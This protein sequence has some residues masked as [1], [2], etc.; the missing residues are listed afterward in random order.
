M[1]LMLRPPIS[2]ISMSWRLSSVGPDNLWGFQLKP[3]LISHSLSQVHTLVT[4]LYNNGMLLLMRP[5][6]TI[7]FKLNNYVDKQQ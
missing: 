2:Y 3:T 4:P 7:D 1:H 6:V 5:A